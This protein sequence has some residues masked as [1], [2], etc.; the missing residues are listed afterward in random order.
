MCSTAMRTSFMVLRKLWGECGDPERVD[1]RTSSLRFSS[2]GVRAANQ[3]G[4]ESCGCLTIDIIAL[5]VQ[6]IERADAD[7]EYHGG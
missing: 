1:R 7:L 5:V 2:V 6:L 4:E 3:C